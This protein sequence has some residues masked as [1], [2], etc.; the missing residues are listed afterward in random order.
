MSDN[1]ETPLD[2]TQLAAQEQFSKQSYR[3]GKGHIL[4]DTSDIRAALEGV[5]LPDKARILDISTGGGHTALFFA[6]QGHA[7]TAS[8]ISGAMLARVQAVAT[9]R[10]LAIETRQHPAEA[11]PYDD[12]TFD[13]VACRVAAHHF[14]SPS[15]FVREAA[16]V[17]KVG[18]VFLLI[19]GSVADEE[20]EA[21]LWMHRVEKFRDP[22]H[23]RF[24]TPGALKRLCGPAGLDVKRCE[25]HP[26][27]QPDLEWYFDTA[28]TS[29][30]NR[31]QV[32]DLVMR[33]PDSALRLFQINIEED[34][35]IV[36]WW[37]RLTLV[38][39]KKDLPPPAPE[40]V[41]A[42]EPGNVSAVSAGPETTAP[43]V[44]PEAPVIAAT[45]AEEPP[46]ANPS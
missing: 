30:E 46:T 35:R 9:E 10:G 29:P 16:R 40:P 38:A 20:P 28:D 31:L 11:L 45:P 18:G 32:L 42:A 13:L 3:Y 43:S 36:W 12:G 41:A 6:D 7:V 23:S 27:K 44:N 1:P 15:R 22:S 25:L 26:M 17:L 2:A 37:Q 34:E 5:T 24:L 39:T 33:A 21:E 4:E 8:D 14:S 19:D